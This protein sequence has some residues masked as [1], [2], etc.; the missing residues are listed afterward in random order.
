MNEEEEEIF[1]INDEDMCYFKE[2]FHTPDLEDERS[3][4]SLKNLGVDILGNA[5][6]LPIQVS[7]ILKYFLFNN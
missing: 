1:T 5:M 7:I 3:S 2:L 4:H 6:H